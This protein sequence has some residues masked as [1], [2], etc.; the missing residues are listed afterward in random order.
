MRF[1]LVHGVGEGVTELLVSQ[2]DSARV[3][4]GVS[5]NRRGRLQRRERQR[6]HTAKWSGIDCDGYGGHSFPCQPLRDHSAKRM[7][8]DSGLDLELSDGVNVV[9]R[10]LRDVLVGK[11]L[12]VA[13]CLLNRF[14]IIG[15]A[16]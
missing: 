5:Q 8:D 3:V 4:E 15:P 6:E 11:D 16:R 1:G 13:L 9:I 2:R 7:T 12:R 10:H 14:W